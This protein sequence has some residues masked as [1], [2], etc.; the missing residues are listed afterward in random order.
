MLSIMANVQ[1][2]TKQGEAAT[3]SLAIGV[4]T[5]IYLFYKLFSNYVYNYFSL[6]RLR[7]P[8]KLIA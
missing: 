2:A 6:F 3:V 8:K 7:T 5:G 1:E 4:L